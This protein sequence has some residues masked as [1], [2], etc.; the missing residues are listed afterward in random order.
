MK[1]LLWLVVILIAGV[2]AFD[3]LAPERSAQNAIALERW[4]AGLTEK[5][6]EIPGFEVA[7]LEGGASTDGEAVVLIHGFGANKDNF[8]RVAAPLTKQYRVLIPDLP[9]FG[10]SSKPMDA[11]YGIRDQVE[12]VRAF[13]QGQGVTRAHL[14]GSSMGGYIAAQYAVT[15]PAEVGSLWL[16]G[17]AGTRAAFENSELRQLIAEKG[18]NPL[19]AQK[20]ED[21]ERTIAFVMHKRPFMP[22]SIRKVLTD[23]AVAS[24]E[25]NT[26]IFAQLN[27]P[28]TP[29]LDEQIEG[30]ATPALVVWGRQDRALSYLGAETYQ[31]LM[32]NAKIVLMDDIGHLPMLEAPAQAAKDYVAF[33]VALTAG[34]VSQTSHGAQ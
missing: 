16:L 6:A 3:F 31:R 1:K 14:G 23:R 11:P 26:R 22:Y 25:L 8:T 13:L 17:P 27:G 7:Y 4:R 28:E 9:G 20:P 30:L 19:I 12:R 15:Y 33:R 34:Q 10:E 2:I 5:R 24:Y 29:L 21:F 18:V 32:P